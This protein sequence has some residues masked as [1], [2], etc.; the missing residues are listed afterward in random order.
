[1]AATSIDSALLNK[2]R[3]F[4]NEY[5]PLKDTDPTLLNKTNRLI[6]YCN[7]S[8]FFVSLN[9]TIQ[10]EDIKDESD[11][12]FR[13]GGEIAKC[14][15]D[16]GYDH[17]RV[18][19]CGHLIL[20]LYLILTL[21]DNIQSKNQ[22]KKKN[23]D[24]ITKCL[25]SKT[26]PCCESIAHSYQSS[27]N[28]KDE[29]QMYLVASGFSCGGTIL[30]A[31][32]IPQKYLP[33]LTSLF[34][35]GDVV[36]CGGYRGTQ[37]FMFNGNRFKQVPTGEYYPIFPLKYLKLRG[38]SFYL[39]YEPEL[40]LFD[41]DISY[42]AGMCFTPYDCSSVKLGTRNTEFPKEIEDAYSAPTDDELPTKLQLDYPFTDVHLI[43]K[44]FMSN[45]Q[46]WATMSTGEKITIGRKDMS[47]GGS[48]HK[49]MSGYW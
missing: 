5:Y 47:I 19:E 24:A 14:L 17:Y 43:Q 7:L 2:A 21:F 16:E 36:D 20:D 37:I 3:N 8:G 38:Y 13:S 29:L 40:L 18:Y 49:M 6:W 45:R 33:Y 11:N 28:D 48:S 1:M 31:T 30:V 39:K 15:F 32:I 41:N 44:C 35:K 27:Y 42:C 23:V 34:E 26:C 4:V 9:P 46:F 12:R 10:P 22:S 25:T